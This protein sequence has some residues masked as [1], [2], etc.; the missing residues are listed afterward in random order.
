[1]A[2]LGSKSPTP[3]RSV[4][5]DETYEMIRNLI[6]DHQIAPGAKVN[7]D[8]LAVQLAVSQTPVR[9]AL[10]R[11]ESDGLIVK[12]ALKGYTAT[13][14]LTPSQ[15]SDLFQ[16][17]LLIEPWAAERAALN[18]D[19]LG[20]AALKAEMQS[21]RTALK[22][23]D[24]E[25]VHALT[26]HDARFHTLVS[27][28]SGNSSVTEAFE[29]THCHLHL[30]RL[31]IATKNFQDGKKG[32]KESIKEFIE[33]TFT[34][35]STK[36]TI[37]EHEAIALAITQGESKAAHKAMETH[38]KSSMKRFSPAAKA[39]HDKRKSDKP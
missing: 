24:V 9:E 32:S 3:R 35:E 23:T 16:L 28:M 7:I 25:Q 5:S 30:F 29:R 22:F 31:Y 20:K 15:F 17:R 36:T 11:L 1:M 37:K 33:H 4:L 14:L 8:A 38:I 21:A 18:T 26:E 12:V 39:M 6:L 19:A 10:A 2:V 34:P 27:S 13:D